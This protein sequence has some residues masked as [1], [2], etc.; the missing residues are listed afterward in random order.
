M[1]QRG[2]RR[3]VVAFSTTIIV[4]ASVLGACNAIIGVTE[5]R[6]K[7]DAGTGLD[8]NPPP[9]DGNVADVSPPEQQNVLE[10][11]LGDVH[12][13]ARKPDGTVACWGDD[14]KDQCAVGNAP[15]G[16]FFSTPQP[17]A[18]ITDAT[19]IGAGKLHTCVV[20]M[21]GTVTCWGD[22]LFGQ[23]GDGNMNTRSATPVFFQG[24]NDAV[25]VSGGGGFTC[26]VHTTGLVSCVGDGLAGQLGN[27]NSQPSTVPVTVAMVP[28]AIA[29]SAGD[30]HACAVTSDG[31]VFCWGDGSNG[32]LGNGML[33]PSNMPVQAP[34]DNVVDV[35]AGSR[36]TCALQRTGRV[37]CWGANDLG[38]LGNGVTSEMPNPSPV[39]LPG[40]TAISVK[41]GKDHVCAA[42]TDGTGRC[43]GS[44]TR[45]QLGDGKIRDDA[46]LAAQPSPV[47][48]S[49][50]S[51][52]LGVGAGGDHSCAPN[53]GGQILCW[54]SGTSGEIGDGQTLDQDTP[55]TVHGYP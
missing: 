16:G 15:D 23:L 7:K 20:H 25:G 41:V 35:S 13:C 49:G 32:Q 47:P 55:D 37:F 12:S 22:D 48:V 31:N 54:G 51:M 26:V 19:H 9:V 34:V 10:V 27:G 5:V 46:S 18:G 2:T 14:S 52:A 3:T 50:L 45:G 39:A 24:V 42:L 40:V 17:V 43:W 30:I 33:M 1:P 6:L 53:K 21:D 11:A 38:Q 8:A 29:V 36:S 44:G 28:N 4:F